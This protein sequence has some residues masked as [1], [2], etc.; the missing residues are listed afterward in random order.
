MLPPASL[1]PQNTYDSMAPSQLQQLKAAL[2]SAGLNRKSGGKKDQKK[3]KGGKSQDVDRAKKAA[4]LDEIRAK[5][6]KFDERE[7]KTKHDVGGRNLKG[8]VG[9]PAASR[10]AGIEQVSSMKPWRS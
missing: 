3:K 1:Q 7:T 4:K 2:N 10:Q 8:V 5:F 9:R 6:N